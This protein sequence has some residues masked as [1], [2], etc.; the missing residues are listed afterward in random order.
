MGKQPPGSLRNAAA[1]II[2][3]VRT[4]LFYI[5]VFGYQSMSVWIR[6]CLFKQVHVVRIKVP[7]KSISV[8]LR[9]GTSDVEV[10]KK[11]FLDNE[12]RLPFTL[13]PC[14]ILDLGANIGLAS[15]F[16]AI[17]Y[18]S[19]KI[20]AV[21]PS[22]DNIVL[23]KQ[24]TLEWPNIIVVEAAAWNKDGTV[25]LVDPGIG[26]WGMQVAEA[27]LTMQPSP[28]RSLSVPTL[29]KQNN[30]DHLD[31]LKVD[32]EGA[33]KEVFESSED[34]MNHVSAVVIELH[35]RYKP[36]CSRAFFN[37][38]RLLPEEC[39]IGENVFVWKTSNQI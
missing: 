4:F 14:S 6:A 17:S 34:W 1:Q 21:E 22:P 27:G 37:A 19:A 12:Y 10:Y 8:S 36:G 32:I 26:P 28:V 16:Y 18:P 3:F 20:V 13:A 2:D 23:L 5:K 11:V 29:L 31:L 30:I 9:A 24:N 39:W 33:E 7:G 25:N 15:L 38:A 35:D